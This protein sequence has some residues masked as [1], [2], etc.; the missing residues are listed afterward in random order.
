MTTL[1]LTINGLTVEDAKKVMK[2]LREI[3]QKNPDKTIFVKVN[4]LQGYK[5]KDT[6]KI[7]KDIFPKKTRAK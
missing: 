7:L 4:G 6:L 3:E 5:I 2:L 1:T